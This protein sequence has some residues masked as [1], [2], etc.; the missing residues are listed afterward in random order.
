VAIVRSTLRVNCKQRLKEV[1]NSMN[2]RSRASVARFVDDLAAVE[3]STPAFNQYARGG[4]LSSANALRRR[5][6]GLYLEQI[7]ERRPA[8][9]LI[10]EAPSY[11]GGRLTGIP[12]VSESILLQGI[13]ELGMFGPSRGYRRC[14]E[15]ERVS[16]EASA[17]MVWGTIRSFD[18]L[19]LLWNAFPFHPYRHGN[20][21]TNRMPGN[22]ELLIGQP[23]ILRLLELF[24]L[25]EVVAVGNRAAESLTLL[26]IA[27]SRVR[28]P[29][30]GG[31][32]KFVEGISTLLGDNARRA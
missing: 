9:M 30:Q 3:L 20:Q 24:D 10:G 31:K 26:G 25:R 14:S 23:F 6:L 18:P 1:P 4:V 2:A 21:R 16:T 19:P 13:E 15:F 32:V 12:F 27:H 11:R 8:T 29:S 7:L 28:H 22:L 5:N 17:T